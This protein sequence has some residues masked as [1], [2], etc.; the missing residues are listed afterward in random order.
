MIKVRDVWHIHLTDGIH[1]QG[2]HLF[3]MRTNAC[4]CLFDFS[5]AH[6]GKKHPVA[7]HDSI[8][9]KSGASKGSRHGSEVGKPGSFWNEG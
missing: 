8:F 4:G 9:P 2:T 6:G 5:P 1:F 3:N 7:V